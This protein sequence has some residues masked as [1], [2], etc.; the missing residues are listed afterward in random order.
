MMSNSALAAVRCGGYALAAL[1]ALGLARAD[2]QTLE[3][4]VIGSG[5]YASD[6][7][8]SART[9]ISGIGNAFGNE[10]RGFLVFD[11]TPLP[12]RALVRSA[13][14]KVENL[15]SAN[16]RAPWFGVY[17]LPHTDAG[18]FGRPGSPDSNRSNFRYI[19]SHSTPLFARR[20][21][22]AVG[23]ASFVELEFNAAGVAD[24]NQ[25]RGDAYY[26]LGLRVT[27]AD[28]QAPRPLQYLF[29]GASTRPLAQRATLVVQY[30]DE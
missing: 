1:F 21:V 13:R 28:A 25:R 6:G 26:A 27:L 24:L 5:S 30:V 11:L 16:D 10:T 18:N 14:L 9:C 2:P 4:P 3:L 19:G 20:D 22:P 12:A 17:G 7:V 23:S 29:G 15:A 8:F